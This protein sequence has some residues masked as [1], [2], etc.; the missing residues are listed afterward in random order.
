MNKKILNAQPTEYKGIK[1]KSRLEVLVY[2]TL[3]DNGITPKYEKETFVL[4][5]KMRSKVPFYNRT[6]VK[7]FHIMSQVIPKIT[8]T[9]DFTFTYKDVYVIIEAKGKENDVFPFKRN[10]F[11]KL[12]DSYKGKVIYF[13]VRSKK[14]LLSALNFLND[15]IK[16]H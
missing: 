15:Y 3:L 2:K 9:P 12:L 5:P 4:S 7:G 1:F 8:Y 13:E 11:R 6:K 10:L 14:E 16:R